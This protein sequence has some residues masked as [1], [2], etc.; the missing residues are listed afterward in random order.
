MRRRGRVVV[1]A[2]GFE[3]PRVAHQGLEPELTF[4]ILQAGSYVSLFF[5]L[6]SILEPHISHIIHQH[7]HTCMPFTLV[8]LPL[9]SPLLFFFWVSCRAG[10]IHFVT[11]N[12]A[13]YNTKIYVFWEAAKD[14]KG[15]AAGGCRRGT[16]DT[17]NAR[18][19][20]NFF[21]VLRWSR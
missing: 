20:L 21:E 2:E 17:A 19:A 6:F 1:M 18:V 4:Q 15:L 5:S 10:H 12:H 8:L 14:E 13:H 9:H 7:K 16:F 3:R 11:V